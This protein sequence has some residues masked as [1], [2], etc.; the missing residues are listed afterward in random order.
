MFGFD[1]L[2]RLIILAF[3]TL[4]AVRLP[5]YPQFMDMYYHL[6]TA[7]AFI[8]AGGYSGWD[9]WQYAPIGRPHLYPPV[10]HI[11]LAFL[12]K[13]GIDKVVLAKAFEAAMP[14]ALLAVI[15]D[16]TKR[17]YSSRLAFFTVIMAGTSYSF[18][19]SLTNYIPSAMAVIFGILAFDQLRKG[20]SIRAAILLIL[21]FYTHTGMSLF[22]ILAFLI[23]AAI[24]RR[25]A[26][27]A[28]FCAAAAALLSAPM[29][30]KGIESINLNYILK[31]NERFFCEF[32][33]I[34][35]FILIPGLWVA[36]IKRAQYALFVSL[37]LASLILLPYPYRFFS[38]Q[39]YLPVIFI[40]AV[41][42]DHVYG[43]F[44]RYNRIVIALSL[45][46][47]FFSPTLLYEKSR[48]DLKVSKKIYY[49]DTSFVN[50]ALPDLNKRITATS[51]WYPAEYSESVRTIRQNSKDGDIIYSTLNLVGVAFS[52]LSERATSNG[53]LPEVGAAGHFDPIG[54]SR[55]I[56]ATVSDKQEYLNGLIARYHLEKA[57]QNKLFIFYVNPCATG[58]M[59]TRRAG[60]PFMIIGLI[61]L[62]FLIFYVNARKIEKIV[63]KDLKL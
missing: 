7:W 15:W 33:I 58:T 38:A 36:W 50:L 18:Y 31:S 22:F 3:A 10:F 13:L 27:K 43:T 41:F 60:V 45:V 11:V 2:S 26:K 19:L 47:L 63:D 29:I 37:F 49:M 12:M 56:I 24:D 61:G 32:K 35:Y 20:S 55:L 28:L 17:N 4:Q 23:Y 42:T 21:C 5:L 25:S 14:I 52:G 16:F 30:A 8:R 51:L 1:N 6:D 40:C 44:K 39:G 62:V 9:F 53:L 59:Q 48:T 57:G 54:A 34:Q 46:F